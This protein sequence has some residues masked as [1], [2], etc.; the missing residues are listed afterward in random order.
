MLVVYSIEYLG[1]YQSSRSEHGRQ[2]TLRWNVTLQSRKDVCIGT[3]RD[4]GLNRRF[5]GSCQ[6]QDRSSH[7][8]APSDDSMWPTEFRIGESTRAQEIYSTQD[9]A[10]F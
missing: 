8:V 6:N 7:R 3:V 5:I 9:I 1:C 10:L 4:N 2:M